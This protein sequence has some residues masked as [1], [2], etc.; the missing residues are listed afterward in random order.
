MHT[1]TLLQRGDEISEYKT[2][3]DKQTQE[4]FITLG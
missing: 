2:L 3:R 4:G 1:V